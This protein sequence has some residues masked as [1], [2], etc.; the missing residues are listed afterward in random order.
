MSFFH[1]NEE[2]SA[3]P[4]VSSVPPSIGR[5]VHYFPDLTKGTVG[6]GNQ[7]GIIAAVIVNVF[8][9]S[10]VNLK[11]LTDGPTDE[12]KTS[13]AYNASGLP[14]TWTWPARV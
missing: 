10:V 6:G 13:V 8:N 11:L 2:H 4:T 7:V 1:P 12:W 9:D 3:T 14:N 5:I